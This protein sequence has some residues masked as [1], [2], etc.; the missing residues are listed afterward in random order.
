MK[1]SKK[2]KRKEKLALE[3]KKQVERKATHQ[4][5]LEP[6]EAA[7][8]V[9]GAIY[10]LSQTDDELAKVLVYTVK[11]DKDGIFTNMMLDDSIS[12]I[13][14]Y[15]SMKKLYDLGRKMKAKY[16]ELTK[17][18]VANY[19]MMEADAVKYMTVTTKKNFLE[20]NRQQREDVIEQMDECKQFM[21]TNP[22]T[23]QI[24]D[25]TAELLIDTFIIRR[26]YTTTQ[27]WQMIENWI[28]DKTGELEIVFSY[29]PIE[30]YVLDREQSKCLM[31]KLTERLKIYLNSQARNRHANGQDGSDDQ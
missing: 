13:S 7:I 21:S 17:D 2:Q 4:E 12:I 29:E 5:S 26:G 18:I 19:E 23:E 14:E 24:M 30:I 8:W 3:R 22:S 31:K 25:K 9:G 28:N 27:L 15:P 1:K 11:Y 20:L 6:Y 10:R 16:A